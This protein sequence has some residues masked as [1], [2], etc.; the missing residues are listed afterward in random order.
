MTPSTQRQGASRLVLACVV[1]CAMW[2]LGRSGPAQAQSTALVQFAPATATVDA[3][4]TVSVQVR[5][6]NVQGLY[7]FDIRLGF[8]PAAV[9][10]I[11]EDGSAEGVQIRPGD[12]LKSD[13]V[14]RNLADN[15]AG[16]VWYA[17]TQLNPSEEVSGSGIAFTVTFRGKLAG[18]S[19]PLTVTYQ[20]LATRS[21]ETIPASSENGEIRVGQVGAPTLPP[22]T[23]APPT[24]VPSPEPSATPL[25]QE[26]AVP[27]TA[28]PTPTSTPLLPTSTSVPTARPT[29]VAPTSAPATAVATV[30]PPTLT[31]VAATA[32]P[33]PVPTHT[34][35][36]PTATPAT[37][38]SN[39]ASRGPLFYVALIVLTF[40]AGILVLRLRT[41]KRS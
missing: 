40:A 20:K 23:Q 38:S 3:G 21:G 24:A 33:V 13:F 32:T 5:I 9:E 29:V 18:A 34:R 25:S 15:A 26:T 16:T 14:V 17:L 4:Q 30:V 19:S 35:L 41:R 1:L 27:P 2:T 22:P 12:L 7:G 31:L 37:S 36:V 10:V 6:E 28:A 11:D 39:R 8:D